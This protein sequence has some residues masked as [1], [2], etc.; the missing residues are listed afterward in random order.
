MSERCSFLVRDM[1]EIIK[2]NLEKFCSV[3]CIFSINVEL[4]STFLLYRGLVHHHHWIL[5]LYY[6]HSTNSKYKNSG[7]NLGWAC[8]LYYHKQQYTFNVIKIYRSNNRN[9]LKPIVELLNFFIS[10]NI[11]SFRFFAHT[12]WSL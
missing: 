12:G 8:L 4:T 10:E 1:L 3:Y 2:I 7:G 6:L 11:N 5:N 9:L